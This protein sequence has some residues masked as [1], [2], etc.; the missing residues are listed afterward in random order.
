MSDPELAELITKA[1]RYLDGLAERGHGTAR[2][3]TKLMRGSARGGRPEL[4]D[5]ELLAEIERLGGGCTAI[6]IVS[7]G[8]AS[9]GRRLRRKR[10]T[11][12]FIS[13][14]GVGI[15]PE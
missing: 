9:I 10:R 6:A 7:G 1:L 15:C 8:N 4:D 12:Q 13:T 3:A 14:R 5:T 2:H 11:E